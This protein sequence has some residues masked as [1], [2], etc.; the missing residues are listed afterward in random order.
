MSGDERRDR[1]KADS[2][3]RASLQ[4]RD[5][6][7]SH[8]GHRVVREGEL[9]MLTRP[10]GGTIYD[11]EAPPDARD[12]VPLSATQDSFYPVRVPAR[13]TRP[14]MSLWT[15]AWATAALVIVMVGGAIGIVG[16]L[17]GRMLS[18]APSGPDE[19]NAAATVAPPKQKAPATGI[20][21]KAL[22]TA[23]P[24]FATPAPPPPASAM[25]VASASAPGS[26]G[27]AGETSALSTSPVVVRPARSVAFRTLD[28]L[29][30]S[31]KP[32]PS[33]PAAPLPQRRPKPA[34]TGPRSSSASPELDD[35]K[36]RSTEA[37]GTSDLPG[38]KG[39]SE[40]WITEERRF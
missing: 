24:A 5:A 19:S 1:E 4:S 30:V 9:Y 28:S 29:A 32:A 7:T 17:R 33:P 26:L 6:P 15:R 18:S 38:T 13:S 21:V 31:P 10:R 27:P 39:E 16:S 11:S 14:P 3:S 8:E 25:R 20:G 35:G 22:P 12:A 34:E 40:A 36:V 23:A 37:P 2:K